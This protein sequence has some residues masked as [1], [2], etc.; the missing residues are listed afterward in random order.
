MKNEKTYFTSNM[1]ELW[2]HVGQKKKKKGK[3]THP[4]QKKTQIRQAEKNAHCYDSI[5][6]KFKT[7]KTNLWS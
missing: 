6:V 5:H 1:D 7:G 4:K 3:K 2:K